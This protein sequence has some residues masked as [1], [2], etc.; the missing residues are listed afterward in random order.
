MRFSEELNTLKNVE[1]LTITGSGRSLEE[2]VIH[3][4]EMA[5]KIMG[6]NVKDVRVFNR[7]HQ[8]TVIIDFDGK[9]CTLNFSF[10][11]IPFAV[12]ATAFNAEQSVYAAIQSDY[13][14]N[15]VKEILIFFDTD[16]YPFDREE[17][18]TIIAIRD[19]IIEGMKATAGEKVLINNN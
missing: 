8:A 19:A 14:Y 6:T 5:V 18:I 12:D 2:Y 15:L 7:K 1:S 10:S 9:L 16:K 4:I 13:F 3:Q 11:A 17:T